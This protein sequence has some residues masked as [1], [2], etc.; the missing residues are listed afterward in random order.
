M[1]SLAFLGA[2]IAMGSWPSFLLM[3]VAVVGG[4]F[5]L[6]AEEKACIQQYG[7]AYREYMQR[8]PRYFLFF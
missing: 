2:S 7:D 8:V 4:H 5:R 3:A 1:L 6:V